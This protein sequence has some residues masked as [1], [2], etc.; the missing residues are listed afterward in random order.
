MTG[1]RSAKITLHIIILDHRNYVILHI[2]RELCYKMH[3]NI[4]MKLYMT[5][6]Y[7]ARGRRGAEAYYL[8][9][10][11]VKLRDRPEELETAAGQ[12]A[13]GD[14]VRL[15]GRRRGALLILRRKRDRRVKR[16]DRA[17][18]L[19]RRQGRQQMRLGARLLRARVAAAA[20]AARVHDAGIV[21][22]GR[23]PQVAAET[24]EQI[25]GRHQ[26]RR[27]AFLIQEVVR[28][29]QGLAV[30]RHAV[31]QAASHEISET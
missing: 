19:G 18:G 27:F 28:L 4:V 29:D 7:R 13:H 12:G 11:E 23:S 2:L 25:E 14:R 24:R 26:Q 1:E 31:H 5:L 3:Y 10:P 30:V 15:T 20:L 17:R 16:A 9:R 8:Q 21:L 22:I 6:P